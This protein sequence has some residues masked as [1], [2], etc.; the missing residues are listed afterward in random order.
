M[1]SP[2]SEATTQAR[3]P[4]IASP[5]GRVSDVVIRTMSSVDDG[6]DGS[7][8]DTSAG[9]RAGALDGADERGAESQALADAEGL[10]AI[11]ASMAPT[12]A[13]TSTITFMSKPPSNAEARSA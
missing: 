2:V 8:E 10:A 5:S 7:G 6:A 9:A 3:L 11:G 1:A 12:I 13:T 4:W